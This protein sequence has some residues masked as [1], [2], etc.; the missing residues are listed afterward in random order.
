MEHFIAPSRQIA[1]LL[2]PF[3]FFS[4]AEAVPSIDAVSGK[5]QHGSDVT[6]SGSG[7]SVHAD[8]STDNTYILNV[9]WNDFENGE[10][11]A[12]CFIWLLAEAFRPN[13]SIRSD[14][15]KMNSNYYAEKNYNRE[16]K[17]IYPTEDTRTGAYGVVPV[18]NCNRIY[19]TFWFKM[20][21][22]NQSG[23][24]LRIYGDGAGGSGDTYI[25]LSSGGGDTYLRGRGC[26]NGICAP[27]Q[28]TSPKAFGYETWHRVELFI[29]ISSGSVTTYIDGELQWTKNSGWV[30][31]TF[32]T[33]NSNWDFGHMVDDPAPTYNPGG[34]YSYD[35]VFFNNTFARVEI[36]DRVSFDACTHREVQI[37]SAWNDNSITFKANQGSFQPGPAYLFVVD[38]NGASGPGFPIMIISANGDTQ[39]PCS[40]AG[41][42]VR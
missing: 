32:T 30:D 39:P 3:L 8:Y 21:D 6:V 15:A 9:A 33:D 18:G 35:D 25:Y 12:G 7:F 29:N 19:E 26:I 4:M 36:G 37:P 16:L 27:E 20:R 41:F 11:E 38:E 10:L 22:N 14:N 28:L 24:F 2:F 5:I 40:P 42:N 23:K 31:S 17:E 34:G 1:F 13:W